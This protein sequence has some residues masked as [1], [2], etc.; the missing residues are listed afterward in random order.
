MGGGEDSCLKDSD[1]VTGLELPE[2]QDGLQWA[3]F[4]LAFLAGALLGIWR[5]LRNFI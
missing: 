4:S 2:S 1:C 3:S 5:I